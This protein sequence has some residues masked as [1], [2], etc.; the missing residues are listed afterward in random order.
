MASNAEF[1]AAPAHAAR[2]ATLPENAFFARYAVALA[3]FIVFGF[4]QFDLR[5]PPP[6]VAIPWVVHAHAA[7]MLAWLALTVAQPRLAGTHARAWH[8]RL[9][10]ASLGLLAAIVVFASMTCIA[11]LRLGLIPPFFT[12][13]Y[14]FALVHVGMLGFIATVFAGIA[15]RRRSDWH[16]RLMLGS[17]VVI[18]EPALGRLL[19]MPLLGAWGEWVAMG[20]QL[21][22]LGWLVARDRRVLGRVHPATVTAAG[23]VVA[24]HAAIDAAAVFPPFV[25]F[26]A[27]V[28]A[29]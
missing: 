14:F 21:G 26:A 28:A 23:A 17:T 19:P 27:R 9:G 6:P 11:A 2:P 10:W 20:V 1:L 3:A 25:A 15:M 18:M 4:A 24:V 7:S 8:R 16:R 29:A 12:P 5:M 13:A 22:A